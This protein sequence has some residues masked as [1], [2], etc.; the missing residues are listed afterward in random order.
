MNLILIA[1]LVKS[2]LVTN[3]SMPVIAR[4]GT[5]VIRKNLTKLYFTLDQQL[6]LHNRQVQQ[7]LLYEAHHQSLVM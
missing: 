1:L 4:P 6:A 7:L 2:H 3:S 5:D